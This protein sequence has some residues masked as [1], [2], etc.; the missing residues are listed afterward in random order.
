MVTVSGKPQRVE[1]KTTRP[2]ICKNN[3]SFVNM[4][5]IILIKASLFLNSVSK[6]N[7]Q[8]S[9]MPLTT[10]TGLTLLPTLYFLFVNMDSS[11]STKCYDHLFLWIKNFSLSQSNSNAMLNTIKLYYCYLLFCF[12]SVIFFKVVFVQNNSK[13]SSFSFN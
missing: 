9:S 3:T 12:L 7:S 5:F 8:F 1:L 11:I 13:S 4:F 2:F 6:K 10:Q